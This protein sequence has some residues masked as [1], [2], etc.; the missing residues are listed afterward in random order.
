VSQ[1]TA[2][3]PPRPGQV[4]E[5]APTQNGLANT[6]VP[7][8]QMTGLALATLIGGIGLVLAG[9]DKRRSATGRAAG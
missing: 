5:G 4:T 2:G 1:S 3:Q 6:G 8:P 7:V 9:R